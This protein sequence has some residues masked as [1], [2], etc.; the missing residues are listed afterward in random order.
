[1]VLVYGLFIHIEDNRFNALNDN[2]YER[3]DRMK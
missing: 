2:C 3:E 1:M